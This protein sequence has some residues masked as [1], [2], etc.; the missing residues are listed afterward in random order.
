[1]KNL[2]NAIFLSLLLLLLSITV[3][4]QTHAANKPA[5][6]NFKEYTQLEIGDILFDTLKAPKQKLLK[7]KIFFRGKVMR[8][9]LIKN[10]EA[11]VYRMVVTCCAAD[12][13]PLGILVKLPDQMRFRNGD[14]VGVEGTLQ[15]LPFNEK[16]KTLEPV[17]N[18]VPPEKIFPYFTATKAYKVN[19][20]R[21]EYIYVQ[22]SY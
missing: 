11:V 20:P 22:Y 19:P 3:T 13:L 9:A 7:S 5:P 10:N 14:W 4:P 21:D 16:L 12:M 2:N 8:S 6:V 15:L 1:M 18:M 17:A